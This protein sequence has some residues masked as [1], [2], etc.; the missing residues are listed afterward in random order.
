MKNLT[1]INNTND[2]HVYRVTG[3]TSEDVLDAKDTIRFSDVEAAE[4]RMEKAVLKSFYSAN[5]G[6]EGCTMEELEMYGIDP[7]YA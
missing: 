7:Y 3:K 1:L 6:Y 4:T 5:P 2:N